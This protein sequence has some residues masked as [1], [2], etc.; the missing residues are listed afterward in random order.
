MNPNKIELWSYQLYQTLIVDINSYFEYDF[1]TY[2]STLPP[3]VE[4]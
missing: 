4:L 2:L 3:L 1:L